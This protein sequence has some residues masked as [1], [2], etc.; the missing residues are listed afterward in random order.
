MWLNEDGKTPSTF[1]SIPEAM[2][3]CLVTVTTVGYGDLVPSTLTGKLVA[4]LVT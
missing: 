2:W 3:W 4:S 1:Q